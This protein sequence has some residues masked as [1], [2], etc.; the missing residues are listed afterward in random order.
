[1][2]SFIDQRLQELTGTKQPF[3]N[4]SIITVGDLYQLQPIRD[5]WVFNYLKK[6]ASSLAPN[7]WKDHF[8]MFEL[9]EIMRQKDDIEFTELLN[10]LR[11]NSLTESDKEN[12]KSC[13]ISKESL[14]YPLNAPHLFAENKFMRAF[15]NQ[16][17]N[18]LNTEKVTVTYHDTILSPSMKPTNQTKFQLR[19]TTT[20]CLITDKLCMLEG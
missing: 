12:I 17:I 7:L 20:I 11:H 13:E 18:N 9:T 16:I 5:G 8:K 3:G 4:V 10:R 15:D 6:G 19:K 2:L 1:M 14:D